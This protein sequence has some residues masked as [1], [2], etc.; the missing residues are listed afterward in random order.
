MLSPTSQLV[1]TALFPFIVTGSLLAQSTTERVFYFAHTPT[2]QGTREIA[3]AIG[4][5]AGAQ[6]V[7]ADFSAGTLSV[8]GAADQLEL[9][10]WLFL[11]MD[12]SVPVSLDTA[13]HEYRLRDGP[14][15]LVRLFYLDRGQTVR[16]FQEFATLVRTIAEIRRVYPI[17][18]AKILAMRGTA[19][20]ISMADYFTNE[21]EKSAGAPHPHSMTSEYLLPSVPSPRPN[22]NV[23]RILFVANSPTIQDFQEL[24]TL[25]RSITEI[26]RLFT[27]NTPKAIAIRGTTDQVA[28]AEWLFNEIDQPRNGESSH[29]SAPYNYPDST[30]TENASSVRVFY[31]HHTASVQDFQKIAD[32]IRTATG[33]RRLFTYTSPHA[34]V[35]RATRDQAEQAQRLLTQLDPA[36]FP[37]AK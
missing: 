16:D 28:F 15:N 24:A 36:D 12:R 30:T 13:V 34:L 32:T 4:V 35:L 14:D 18:G 17:S 6:D 26:R 25:I 33:I 22:E 3:T 9:A 1:L 2:E 23:T 29:A 7:S 37:M 10:E 19:D 21:L 5:I 31:L 20:Q 11:G 27:Y 8:H